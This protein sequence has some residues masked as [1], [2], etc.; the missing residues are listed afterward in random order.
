MQLCALLIS[1]THQALEQVFPMP[2]ILVLFVLKQHWEE[3]FSY[4]DKS[5]LI[6]C[7]A[8]LM[9]YT[10]LMLLA[11]RVTDALPWA[12]FFLLYFCFK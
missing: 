11:K 3:V 8:F 7:V 2:I 4:R 10:E 1:G 12:E 6:M 5:C 9:N